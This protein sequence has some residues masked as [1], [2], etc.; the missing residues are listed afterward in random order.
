[1]SHN[2]LKLEVKKKT[3]GTKQG[4]QILGESCPTQPPLEIATGIW[5]IVCIQEPSH[6]F[7]QTFPPLRVFKIVFRD[8]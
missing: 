8:C 5:V 2:E 1:M 6:H 4:P 7:L 3:G